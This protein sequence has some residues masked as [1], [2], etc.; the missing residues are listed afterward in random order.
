ME[1]PRARTGIPRQRPTRYGARAGGEG[2][3]P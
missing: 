3:E 2:H 1:T